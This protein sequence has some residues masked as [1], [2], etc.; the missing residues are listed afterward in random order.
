[1]LISGFGDRD[2]G[3][4]LFAF[5][6]A[7]VQR[8]DSIS[9]TGLAFNGKHLVR[10]LRG[11]GPNSPGELVTYDA[12][13]VQSY[14]RIDELR[15]AHDVIWDG[16]RLVAVS[17]ESNSVLWL[18][19]SGTVERVWIA[20]GAG[21]A[22]HLN[23]LLVHA[24]SLLVSA[25]G[26][27]RRHREWLE[28]M[29]AGDGILFDPETGQDRVTGLC[30]PHSPKY[31]DGHIVICSSAD[32]LL[33]QFEEQGGRLVRQQTLNGW[34][35]GLAYSDDFIFVGESAARQSDSGLAS[36]AILS[37][38]NW[39]ILGRAYVPCREIYDL[40]LVPPAFV[41]SARIGFRTNSSRVAEQDQLYM[42]Q[43]LGIQPTRL[44]ASG[45]PL[46]PSDC[47]VAL[48]ADI[49]ASLQAGRLQ[50]IGIKITNLADKFLV[51]APPHPVFLSYKWFDSQGRQQP[52][53][54]R[55]ALPGS[56][57]P[58][59][60]ASG[61]VSVRVPETVGRSRLRVT[62]VQEGVAWFDDI[63]DGNCCW[64]DVE[65]ISDGELSALTEGKQLATAPIV[66]RI[67]SRGIRHRAKRL[68]K[69]F[70]N[71]EDI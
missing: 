71:R 66:P 30:A 60:S 68:M 33:V 7:T 36:I 55:T 31:I 59:H 42:F 40:L 47:R 4:G 21:D 52:E 25:F 50:D 26:K 56:L 61:I 28:R 13:G 45:D 20:P 19:P 29:R 32:D 37:R 10:A 1:M 22:W 23:G 2:T 43:Q 64:R 24:G 8:I 3:G 44:W 15:D 58:R 12:R 46:K 34:T 5:D 57:P 35:R 70:M 41:E 38:Q 53:G 67:K 14:W 17:A 16:A 62:L 51:S 69:K 27:Y 54:Q 48:E 18:S 63:A 9:S 49:P 65:I 39:S 6:G 11:T